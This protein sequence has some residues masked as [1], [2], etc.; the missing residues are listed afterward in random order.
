M[1]DFDCQD[2]DFPM[3]IGTTLAYLHYQD[4]R[5]EPRKASEFIICEPNK[6]AQSTSS[7]SSS[8]LKNKLRDN[9]HGHKLK[10]IMGPEVIMLLK[11]KGAR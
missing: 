2:R 5:I 3:Y 6:V 1:N 9:V 10:R 7:P 4:N 11:I 8:V